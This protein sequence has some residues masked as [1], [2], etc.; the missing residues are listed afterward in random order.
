[1]KL[2]R[3]QIDIIIEQ[4][5]EE[6]KGKAASIKTTLGYYTPKQANWSYIVGW[7]WDGDLVCTRFG[8]IM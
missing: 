1:M 5:R 3:K 6:L 2:T 4:T 8:H 7:T